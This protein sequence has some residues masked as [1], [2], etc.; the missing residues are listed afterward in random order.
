MQVY[1][2]ICSQLLPTPAKSHYTFNLRDLAKVFQGILM[3]DMGKSRPQFEIL[4]LW[5]H[6]CQRVFA[7]R[8]VNDQ[9][10]TWFDDLLRERLVK[11]F[12]TKHEDVISGDMLVYGD[13]MVPNADPRMYESIDDVEK[14]V[15]ILQEYLED[16]NALSTAQM[17]LVL[18]LDAVSHVTRISRVIRQPLG[19]ALLLGVGG[20]GRQSLTRLAAHMA[21]YDL[22]QVTHYFELYTWF[23]CVL[24]LQRRVHVVLRTKSR[25]FSNTLRYVPGNLIL[26][27]SF[28]NA[29]H[30]CFRLN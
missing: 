21:E 3:L 5:Y 22:F 14:M 15:G 29:Y 18:F 28:K 27:S 7:D 23:E 20:S 9:D 12:E 16:Y 4:R 2:T 13:F 24:N 1:N 17:K 6:E 19:N 10:R 25:N 30:F 8:L 26:S 11:D